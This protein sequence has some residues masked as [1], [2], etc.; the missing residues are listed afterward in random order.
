[1]AT[2]R[3]LRQAFAAAAFLSCLAT[4]AVA[5]NIRHGDFGAF[6]AAGTYSGPVR[7]PDFKGRDRDWNDYR[8]R[9]RD[10]MKG[11]ANFAGKLAVITVGC[12][13]GCRWAAVGDIST[14]R[15]HQFPLGGEENMYL[16]LRYRRDS[17]L[18]VAYWEEEDR[19]MRENLEW[20][21]SG[22]RQFGRK[23]IGS[24]DVCR[25]IAVAE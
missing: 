25:K 7:F 22:F 16:E 23:A 15:V 21:G 14:G 5:Q 12:G 18:I 2:T 11:G 19:C 24:T 1:M 6:P 13:T 10:G 9:I 17:R 8:T 4:A 3:L 20:T